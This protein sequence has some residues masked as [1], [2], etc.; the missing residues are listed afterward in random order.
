MRPGVVA[1]RSGQLGRKTATGKMAL[2]ASPMIAVTERN[3]AAYRFRHTK[4]ELRLRKPFC[5][6]DLAQPARARAGSNSEPLGICCIF[7]GLDEVS[8]LPP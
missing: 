5:G 1:T 8:W 7:N 3:L 4:A 6:G 2:G